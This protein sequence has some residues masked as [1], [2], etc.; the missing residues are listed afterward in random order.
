MNKFLIVLCLMFPV[1]ALANN[2]SMRWDCVNVPDVVGY[3]VYR[4]TSSGAYNYSMPVNTSPVPQPSSCTAGGVAYTD[5]TAPN[6]LLFYVVRAINAAGVFSASSNEVQAQPL[7]PP[8]P[9][10]LTII[11]VTAQLNLTVNGTLVASGPAP[12]NYTI[13]RQSP[14]RSYVLSITQQ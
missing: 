9:T 6:A 3:Y 12:L 14:P 10:N 13:P 4:A 1:D 7:G 2:V 8:A 11:G 5:S